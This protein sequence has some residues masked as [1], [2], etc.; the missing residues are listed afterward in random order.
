MEFAAKYVAEANDGRDPEI[1]IVRVMAGKE[2]PMFSC[3]FLGWDPEFFSKQ[4]FSDPYEAKLA[5]MKDAKAKQASS[6]VK[7]PSATLKK[8]PSAAKQEYEKRVEVPAASPSSPA[9]ASYKDP[10][11][12]AFSL[13]DLQGN[14]PAGVDPTQKEQYL[15][16]GSFSGLFGMDKAAFDKLPKW[17]RDT[18]KKTHGL[19]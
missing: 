5:A 17:K 13:A 7:Q 10:K 12:N 11:S 16:D 8:V 2:P 3:H 18:A 15:D 6:P 9:N 4:Q 19:F 1:P 14:L